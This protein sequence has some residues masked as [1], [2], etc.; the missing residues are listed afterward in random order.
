MGKRWQKLAI[1]AFFESLV[2][3]L[4]LS[5]Q[6]KLIQCLITDDIAGYKGIWSLEEMAIQGHGKLFDQERPGFGLEKI[7]SRGALGEGQ[8]WPT[9]VAMQQPGLN[10]NRFW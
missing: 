8:I 2:F 3:A 5:S 4:S 10:L 7:Q 1:I 6:V 9:L